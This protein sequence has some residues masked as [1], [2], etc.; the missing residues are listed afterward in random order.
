MDD[1]VTG[2]GDSRIAQIQ[3]GNIHVTN[4]VSCTQL[5][6]HGGNF[7][8]SQRAIGVNNQAAGCDLAGNA[9]NI[10]V[11]ESQLIHGKRTT[12]GRIVSLLRPLILKNTVP[13][14]ARASSTRVSL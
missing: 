3:A 1:L 12:T 14:S 13:V 2:N 11:I 8:A 9:I 4:R 7:D 5:N 10:Q 6:T